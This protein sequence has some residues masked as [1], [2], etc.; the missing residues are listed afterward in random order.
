MLSAAS[1]GL[2]RARNGTGAAHG[3]GGSDQAHAYPWVDALYDDGGAIERIWYSCRDLVEAD[4][5]AQSCRTGTWFAQ[6]EPLWDNIRKD[7]HVRH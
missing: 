2:H 4:I 1:A 5:T 6:A 7:G 3:K